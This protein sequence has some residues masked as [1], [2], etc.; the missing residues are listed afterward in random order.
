MQ[1]TV[2]QIQKHTILSRLAVSVYKMNNEQLDSLL[3]KLEPGPDGKRPPIIPSQVAME[4]RLQQWRA[5]VIARIFVLIHQLDKLVLLQRLE[6][7][8]DS[9]F[10]WVREFPRL[11]CFLAVDFASEGRSYRSCI[12]DIS[13]GGVFIE[14]AHL[15]EVDQEIAL[16]FTLSE[17]NETLPFK[18]KGAVTRIYPDGIGVRYKNITK[19]QREIINALLKNPT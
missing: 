5:L 17:A 4:K 9:D 18:I 11:S 13:A 16:C 7:F 2:E 8:E 14:T 10:Q 12:R 1:Y 15:F 3:D 6:R 19:Y